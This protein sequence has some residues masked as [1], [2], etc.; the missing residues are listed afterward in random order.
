MKILGIETSCDETAVAIVDDQKN[1]LAH[2]INSQIA[3]H[4]KYGGVVPELAAR[5]HADLLDKLILQA[6]EQANL[7]LKEI[8]AFA[9]TAGPGLIGGVIVGVMAAKTLASVY[10]KP[11]IAV[12]HLEAHALTVRLTSEV[13]FPYLLLLVSGGHCQILLAKAIG[14]Y[15]KIGETMDDALGEA[16]DKVAQMLGLV[17]PGGP[18]IEKLALEGDE[19][20]FKFPRPLIDGTKNKDHPFDFSFSGLKTAVR[21]Q[22]EKLTGQEFSH[23]TSASKLSNQDK[24][25]IA[26]SFQ[27]TAADIILNRLE[28]VMNSENIGEISQLQTLVI[29]GG[30]AANR[31]IFSKLKSWAETKN[32]T[33]ITPPIKLCTDNAAMIAWTGIERLKLGMTDSLD[34]KPKARWP[35]TEF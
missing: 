30:V 15:K 24:A 18:A 20:F 10:K 17:Y 2:V 25:N 11:F 7:S 16:F 4:E 19:N 21:R 12:N 33:T 3:L 22:I 9:V 34:F 32:L 6:L 31:H 28:N 35:L 14:S 1:I 23:T 29:A 8:D 26:A 5:S 27:K 13:Q